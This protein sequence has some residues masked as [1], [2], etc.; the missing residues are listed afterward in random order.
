M[1]KMLPFSDPQI[2]SYAG[3]ANTLG[4]LESYPNTED[5]IYSNFFQMIYYQNINESDV[6]HE[7]TGSMYDLEVGLRFLP[8]YIY[9]PFFYVRCI[10]K[11]ILLQESDVLKYIIQLIDLNY[12]FIGWA[13]HYY[14]P[15]SKKY[16]NKHYDD[17]ILIYGY[18]MSSRKLFAAGFI[19]S[20]Y[21]KIEIN[22]CD[23]EKAIASEVE[24]NKYAKN[25][26]LIKFDIDY[27]Y[28][29]DVKKFKKKV[30]DYLSS[31]DS[32]KR[33]DLIDDKKYWFGISYYD[34][35]LEQF[36]SKM[37]DMRL[38]HNL[39]DQKILMKNRLI[40]L[41]EEG[42]IKEYGLRNLFELNDTMLKKLIML[43]NKTIKNNI[44]YQ[45]EW[46]AE[47]VEEWTRSLKTIK[48]LDID[49]NMQLLNLL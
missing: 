14:I 9:C 43:R 30:I 2:T 18:N 35:I 46:K 20:F 40:F 27:K 25:I 37:Q 16:N 13:D 34:K 26:S 38:V 44:R 41:K 7:M 6:L 36:L 47:L 33:F 5:F 45:N 15:N 19:D 49:F 17:V 28:K 42:Y 48:F 39:V 31:R 11:E 3:I 12:Y 24:M 10:N 21:R 29:F 4:I 1:Q 32:D 22:F 23:F 8:L